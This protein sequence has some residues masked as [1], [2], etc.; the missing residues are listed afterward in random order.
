MC[1][2]DAISGELRGGFVSLH[3]N[4]S[5]K[6]LQ[7]SGINVSVCSCEWTTFYPA[8]Q[9]CWH[10]L[11]NCNSVRLSV[12]LSVTRVLCDEIEEHT[13]EILTPHERKISL[14]FRYQ[15][16][17]VGDVTLHLQ[18]AL[19]VTHPLW[20][21]TSTFTAYKVQ[22][23]TVSEKSPRIVNRKLTVRFLTSYEWSAYVT[24][25][26]PKGWF[27]KRICRYCK[28]NSSSIE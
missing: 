28:K 3:S 26:S 16:R 8:K 19:K 18:F 20:T 21:P 1:R 25:N 24:P 22:T 12:R 13:A 2:F 15:K 6:T 9:L 7:T 27:K 17:L 4:A 14:V 10:G 23:V 11:G 5:S